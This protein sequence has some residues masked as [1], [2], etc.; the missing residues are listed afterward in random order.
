[1]SKEDEDEVSSFE[2]DLQS[3]SSNYSGRNEPHTPFGTPKS[4]VSQSKRYSQTSIVLEENDES[5]E[6]VK[7]NPDIEKL[8]K[9]VDILKSYLLL[10]R[11]QR[12]IDKHKVSTSLKQ[13]ENLKKNY[14]E[15]VS[16]YD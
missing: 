11:K 6:N 5:F 14:H 7:T 4:K 1:M 3:Q 2:D 12:V 8:I 16:E 15:K 9:K 13:F 10:E